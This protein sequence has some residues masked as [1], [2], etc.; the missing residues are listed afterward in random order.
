MMETKT[1]EEKGS[2]LELVGGIVL[3]A[4]VVAG[5][6]YSVG[7]LFAAGASGVLKESNCFQ[8]EQITEGLSR[9]TTVQCPE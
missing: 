8:H 1:T 3:A 7:F 4:A 9:T 5:L 6:S 2:L